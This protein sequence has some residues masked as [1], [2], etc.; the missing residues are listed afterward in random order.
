MKNDEKQT[1]LE[2]D[3]PLVEKLKTEPEVSEKKES[4]PKKKSSRGKL[5]KLETE[6]KKLEEELSQFKDRYLRLAA[7]FDNFKKLKSKEVDNRIRNVKEALILDVLPILDDLDRTLSAVSDEDKSSTIGNGVTMIRNNMKQI[8]SNYGLQEINSI[9]EEFDVDL[10][11]AL[12]M[13]KDEN[14]PTNVVVQEHLKGYRL[15]G[16][17]IRHAKVAINNIESDG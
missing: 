15:N 13:I 5:K 16:K 3:E 14:F 7:E 12:M 8:L 17:V 9:G 4:K 1:T 2:A 6:N 10:H 11:E